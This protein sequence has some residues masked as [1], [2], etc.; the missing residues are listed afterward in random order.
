M[1]YYMVTLGWNWEQNNDKYLDMFLDLEL[2]QQMVDFLSMKLQEWTYG[3]TILPWNN[4]FHSTSKANLVLPL[5]SCVYS[6]LLSI[7][8]KCYSLHLLDPFLLLG[9]HQIQDHW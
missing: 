9:S 6:V 1:F 2:N 3:P 7:T 4:H 5:L 8:A